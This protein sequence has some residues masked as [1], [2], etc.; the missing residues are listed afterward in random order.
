MVAMTVAASPPWPRRMS[1]RR[2]A[3]KRAKSTMYA[4]AF[5]KITAM[6]TREW[7]MPRFCSTRYVTAAPPTPPA[8]KRWAAARPARLM[9][10][11]RPSETG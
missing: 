11:A 4:N 7:G 1:T 9:R 2:P 5:W 8:E 10:R 6:S 3:A